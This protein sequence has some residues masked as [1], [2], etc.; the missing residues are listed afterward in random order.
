MYVLSQVQVHLALSELSRRKA[1]PAAAE[2]E[3]R[4]ALSLQ[5]SLVSRFPDNMPYKIWKGMIQ[6]SLAESLIDLGKPEEAGSLLESAISE[7]QAVPEVDSGGPHLALLE[8]GYGMLAE[9]Y[10]QLG[11]EDL[12]EEVLRQAEQY[13]G[14]RRGPPGLPR[15]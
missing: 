6:N 1:R 10:R 7:L 15:R 9:V 12:A 4:E 8:Q 5:T 2:A 13:R 3:L 14:P 11:Q